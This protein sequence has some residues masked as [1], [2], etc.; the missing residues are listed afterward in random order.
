MSPSHSHVTGRMTPPCPDL[1]R[2]RL[3]R[4]QYDNEM[5]TL[6]CNTT[7]IVSAT[8]YCLYEAA[9]DSI[10]GFNYEKLESRFSFRLFTCYMY[11]FFVKSLFIVLVY[12]YI[13]DIQAIINSI[14]N[15]NRL[16]SV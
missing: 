4:T 7:T 10:C 8:I 14:A 9:C 12:N 15:R 5:C 13:A 6:A 2:Q 3:I 16:S 11:V 1:N